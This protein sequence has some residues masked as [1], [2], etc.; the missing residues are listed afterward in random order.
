MSCFRSL[1]L[2]SPNTQEESKTR[3]SFGGRHTWC[4]SWLNLRP[5]LQAAFLSAHIP[6][7][8]HYCGGSTLPSP[9]CACLSSHHLC[10]PPLAREGQSPFKA[11]FQPDTVNMSI[12]P[13]HGRLRQDYEFKVSHGYTS[14]QNL[15]QETEAG[16]MAQ[17]LSI[18]AVLPAESGSAPRTHMAAHNSQ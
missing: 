9:A 12:I 14:N 11:L 13:A 8:T 3:K 17:W 1:F 16:E 18:L 10:P 5:L 4:T 2:I 15:S 6:H 7:P